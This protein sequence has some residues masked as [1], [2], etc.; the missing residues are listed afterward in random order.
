MATGSPRERYGSSPLTLDAELR[1]AAADGAHK[2]VF[3]LRDG[4][5]ELTP[6]DLVELAARGAATLGRH[7]VGPG[8][9]VGILGPNEPE[10][11]I[12]AFAAWT[13][14]AAVVPLGFP[15]RVRE[16][17][18]LT[19]H[20]AGPVATSKC[21]AV[22]AEPSL[23]PHVP[24]GPAVISWESALPERAP[25][26]REHGRSV[27]DPAVIQFTSGSTSAPKGVVL[28]HR[29]VL[30]QAWGLDA[31]YVTDRERD[32]F[33]SW[34]PLFHDNGL[35]LHLVTP[36][37]L[38]CENH[39]IPTLRFAGSPR[40]WFRTISDVG[41]T[42]TSGPPSAWAVAMRT[43]VRR[44]EGMDLSSLGIGVLTAEMIQPEVVDLLWSRGPEI[45][46]RPDVLSAGYGMAEATLA[47]TITPRRERITVDVV[48]PD[49]FA[50]GAASTMRSGEAK[51][52]VSCGRP[53]P[54]MHVR[55]WRDGRPARDRT[56][57]EIQV[58]G[59]CVMRGYM[60][61]GVEQPF[62][63]LGEPIC[64]DLLERDDAEHPV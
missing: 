49:R 52:L 12:W 23:A 19:R 56:I 51:R 45:G 47:V 38:Q 27:D 54:G 61:D 40:L 2:L 48:D 31:F 36:L 21:R 28:T 41:G 13:A 59:P 37:V 9:A 44:P 3:H 26:S 46:L 15:T 1:R 58:E 29:Q 14:G 63:G 35:F 33:V 50:D 4:D 34:L 25:A 7:G 17:E 57:G 11:V 5:R 53:L 42:I 10:W 64:F 55:V 32:R 60:G 18:A 16:P 43:T 6:G 22:V 8:D 62:V 20:L 24:A 39:L 30:S